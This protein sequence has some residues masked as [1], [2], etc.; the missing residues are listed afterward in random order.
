MWHSCKPWSTAASDG[1]PCYSL[2]VNADLTARRVPSSSQCTACGLLLVARGFHEK[3]RGQLLNRCSDA[4]IAAAAATT[5]AP[6]CARSERR[7][8]ALMSLP[9]RMANADA[10]RSS[11]GGNIF[12]CGGDGGLAGEGCLSTKPAAQARTQCTCHDRFIHA[13]SACHW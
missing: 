9:A 3:S 8:Q 7:Q 12:S 13:S 5:P 2:M 6:P 10:P 11:D 1:G 4:R